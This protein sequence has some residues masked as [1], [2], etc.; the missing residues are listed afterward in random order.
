MNLND[1]FS[2]RISDKTQ[3][4]DGQIKVIVQYV[5][6]EA[7]QLVP[8]VSMKLFVKE[9]NIPI[10]QCNSC[11]FITGA[12]KVKYLSGLRLKPIP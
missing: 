2:I 5:D 3:S 10:C 12:I 7:P 9:G 11:S 4:T 1:S 6:G 8:G